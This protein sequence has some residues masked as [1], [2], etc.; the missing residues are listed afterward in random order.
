MVPSSQESPDDL[1]NRWLEAE[2]RANIRMNR[3]D[4][5]ADVQTDEI[6]QL[7]ALKEDLK[8]KAAALTTRVTSVWSGQ[9]KLAVV[10]RNTEN[11]QARL[12][13][14]IARLEKTQL[15]AMA[16]RITGLS[17]QKIG[18]GVNKLRSAIADLEDAT[19]NIDSMKTD[20]IEQHR[21]KKWVQYSEKQTGVVAWIFKAIA[22]RQ[23]KSI[24]VEC[25]TTKTII[26]KK[27]DA[28]KTD[29]HF[30]ERCHA[31]ITK[32][33]K[34]LDINEGSINLSSL[35][36]PDSLRKFANALQ[37]IRN[38]LDNGWM[39][40]PVDENTKEAA[41]VL[42]DCLKSV[43]SNTLFGTRVS[44][45]P[46]PVLW[47]K[48]TNPVDA[49][50]DARSRIDPEDREIMREEW[51]RSDKLSEFITSFRP[52]K[53]PNP[54]KFASQFKDVV[55]NHMDPQHQM[56]FLKAVI[57]SIRPAQ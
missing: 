51:R 12:S 28:F 32:N 29:I 34:A 19:K 26:R 30:I 44:D 55:W 11:T 52:G 14:T 49:L 41:V 25:E 2:Q 22:E 54:I 43:P 45:T 36:S 16:Q 1:Y 13:E 3:V 50:D 10:E 15:K 47:D 27:I 24:E 56:L 18:C 8:S 46:V 7:K 37:L 23:Q 9:G 17:S 5:N 6:T 33:L 38:S 21:S 35:T 31:S 42:I 20:L 57:Q 4:E 39:R 53:V 40:G 48:F